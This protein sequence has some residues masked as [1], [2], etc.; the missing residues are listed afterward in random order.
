MWCGSDSDSINSL[1]PQRAEFNHTLRARNIPQQL[2]VCVCECVCECVCVSGRR[3]V[4]SP[5]PVSSVGPVV[6]ADKALVSPCPLLTQIVFVRRSVCVCV[7]RQ[8]IEREWVSEGQHTKNTLQ[9]NSSH[10]VTLGPKS[11]FH[12]IHTHQKAI[13]PKR[14]EHSKGFWVK[15]VLKSV[16][17]CVKIIILS[18]S[19]ASLISLK[20]G[21]G[22][23]ANRCCIYKIINLGCLRGSGGQHAGLCFVTCVCVYLCV[24][25]G[26]P[27]DGRWGQ[28][29]LN[30]K[31]SSFSAQMVGHYHATP[32]INTHLHLYHSL[33]LSSRFLWPDPV[34]RFPYIHPGLF[35]PCLSPLCLIHI[36]LSLFFWLWS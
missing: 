10:C 2:C 34:H 20:A 19:S 1:C 16:C 13:I 29:C 7:I 26:S 36:F 15:G 14:I 3:S 5:R 8:E 23:I 4:F 9:I 12:F 24:T 31:T 21:A 18:N 11:F 32:L 35:W 28:A 30:G 27:A 17:V 25:C 33:F 6:S 22:L